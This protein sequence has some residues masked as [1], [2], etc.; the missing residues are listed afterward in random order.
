MRG[1]H[2]RFMRLAMAEAHK[3]EGTT[4]PYPFVGCV[5]VRAGKVIARGHTQPKG[6]EHAEVHALKKLGRRAVGATLYSTLEPCHH[7]D[8]TDCE[9]CSQWIARSG[10]R[11]VVWGTTDPNPKN[12]SGSTRWLGTRGITVVT[13]VLDAECAKLHEIFLTSLAKHRPFVL[14]ST[15]MSLDGKITWKKDAP[16]QRFSSPEGLARVQELRNTVDAMG[17]GIRT[18]DIDNPRLTVRIPGGRNPHRIVFDS[19]ARLSPRARLFEAKSG[20]VYVLTTQRAP[21]ARRRALERRGARV[22]VLPSRRD[23]RVDLAKAFRW[24]Y[25]SERIT[26]IMVEGGGELIASL[27]HSH[28][29]DKFYFWYSPIIIG[30]ADTPTA[31]EGPELKKFTDATTIKEYSVERVGSDILVE[32]YVGNA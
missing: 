32:G 11:T 4:S 26:S 12:Q 8:Y 6:R 29:V 10:V 1:S 5:I 18:A 30:G 23:G 7:N 15:A 21:L 13:R 31:V 28:L 20:R 9:P 24:L 19:E 3:G 22:V 25:T 17:V 14:L 16:P 27:F 2:E